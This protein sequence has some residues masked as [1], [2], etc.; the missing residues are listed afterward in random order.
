MAHFGIGAGEQV[1][2]GHFIGLL[3]VALLQLQ[4]ELAVPGQKRDFDGG[5]GDVGD[6]AHKER[7]KAETV[8]KGTKLDLTR[9]SP[10]A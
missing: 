7:G 2:L 10:P 8:P 3:E 4:Q 1:E 9:L 6:V 5:M